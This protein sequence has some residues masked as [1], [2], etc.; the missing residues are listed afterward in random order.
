MAA[1]PVTVPGCLLLLNVVGGV[2]VHSLAFASKPL[3]QIYMH[4]LLALG[5]ASVKYLASKYVCGAFFL[6]HTSDSGVRLLF[7]TKCRCLWLVSVIVFM[8]KLCSERVNTFTLQTLNT[9]FAYI[10]SK[11]G[12]SC[13]GYELIV[14]R[15]NCEHVFDDKVCCMCEQADVEKLLLSLFGWR[16]CVK[17]VRPAPLFLDVSIVQTE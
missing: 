11:T 5:H 10:D 8:L 4:N 6:L 16:A 1:Q 13:C 17:R 12:F 7:T 15:G 9:N 2:A 3:R 14:F